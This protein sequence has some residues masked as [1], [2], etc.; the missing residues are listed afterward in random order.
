MTPLSTRI[1]GI[2]AICRRVIEL[3]ERATKGPW[4][5]FPLGDQGGIFIGPAKDGTGT[6]CIDNSVC[7]L[8]GTWFDHQSH[9]DTPK[10]GWANC[11]DDSAFIASMR[12][13]GPAAAQAV[14][15]AIEALLSISKDTFTDHEMQEYCPTAGSKEATAALQ[16]IVDAFLAANEQPL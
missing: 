1:E 7:E 10:E 13:F 8:V 6:D 5:I 16:K 4:D 12:Q 14:L 9:P 11:I 15:I 3:G 2:K